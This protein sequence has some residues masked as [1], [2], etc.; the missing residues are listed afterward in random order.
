[1]FAL[2]GHSLIAVRLLSRALHRRLKFST[3]D[4]FQAP[5]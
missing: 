3:A 5:V 1:M 2:G 4:L